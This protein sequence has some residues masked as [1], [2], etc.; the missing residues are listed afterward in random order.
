MTAKPTVAD[1]GIDLTRL[2]WQ[3]SG[4]GGGAIEIAFAPEAAPAPASAH[5]PTWVLMR[6]AGDPDQRVLVF[7]RNE[8]E[9][10]LDGVR[11]GEFDDAGATE[12]TPRPAATARPDAATARPDAATTSGTAAAS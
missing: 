4:H 12:A 1:L 6:V 7:D 10:F 9:C 3:R 8:W 11:H 5:A 2:T